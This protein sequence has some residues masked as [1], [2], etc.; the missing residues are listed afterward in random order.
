MNE[1]AEIK[2]YR[3]TENGTELLVLIPERQFQTKIKRFAENKKV[4]AMIRIDDNRHITIEQLRKAHVLM[5]EIATYLG[6]YMEW[7]KS[8]MKSWYVEVYGDLKDGFSMANMS[9]DQA[10]R[11]INL[12]IEFAF[13]MDIPL[14]YKDMPIIVE[15]NDYL[16]ICLRYKKCAICGEKAEVHHWDTVGANGG[17]KYDDSKLRKIALCDK[18]H[19]LYSDSMHNI[20]RDEFAKKY[21]VHGI[22]YIE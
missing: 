16:Y 21:H 11:F 18:H 7:F 1:Y 3:N 13:E 12:I 17:R 19:R 10:R 2:G 6:Y 20:G 15:I 5:A 22:I 4:K 14:R 8:L 9:V